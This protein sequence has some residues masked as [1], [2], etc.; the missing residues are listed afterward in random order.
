MTK[1][2]S[3]FKS[4]VLRSVKK[5]AQSVAKSVVNRFKKGTLREY[6]RYRRDGSSV[7]ALANQAAG[8][9]RS[10]IPSVSMPRFGST[11]HHKKTNMKRSQPPNSYNPLIKKIKRGWYSRFL[12]FKN[13]SKFHF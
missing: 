7:M 10:R 6:R 8:Y 3:P 12:K 5:N 1:K 13:T 4:G 2:A 11:V 9:I